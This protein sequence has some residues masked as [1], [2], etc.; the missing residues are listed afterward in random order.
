V[1]SL[2]AAGIDAVL[3]DLDDTLIS[4]RSAMHAAGAAAVRRLWPAVGERAALEGGRR[5]RSDPGGHFAAYTRGELDFG[6]MRAARVRDLGDWLG[7]ASSA[8]EVAAFEEAYEPAFGAE[9]RAF[10]DVLPLL[11]AL[12]ATGVPI[13]VLTNSSGPYTLRKLEVTGL[14]AH[15]GVVVTRDSLGFGKPDARVFGHACSLLGST[16]TRTAYIGDELAVDAIG[17][18]EAGLRAVWIRR[19]GYPVEVGERRAAAA[20]GIPLIDRLDALLEV[21]TGE[22]RPPADFGSPPAAG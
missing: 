20:R 3:L 22:S 6:A 4:T 13:G 7:I 14:A 18:L 19:S 15:V 1:E 17:A 2:G 12:G 21:L 10:D 9:L 5:F 16:P 11:V 8:G